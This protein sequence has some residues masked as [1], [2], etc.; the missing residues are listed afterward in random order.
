MTHYLKPLTATAMLLALAAC[1]DS[2]DNKGDTSQAPAMEAATAEK[3]TMD[4]AT[5][6]AKDMA[7]KAVESLKLDTSSL[8]AFKTS[9]AN[10]KG[11]L[12]AEDQSKLM[13]ALSGMVADSKEGSSGLMDTAKSMASGKSLTETLYEKMG[14]KLS[15]KTFEDILA[16]AG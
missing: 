8:D 5:E 9:L 4:K 10:M 16:M 6:A 1:G 15:G 14:D 12:S 7:T 11:S 3:S 13:D 2:S